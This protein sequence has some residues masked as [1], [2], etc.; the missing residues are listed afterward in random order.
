MLKKLAE[1]FATRRAVKELSA[2]PVFETGRE[3]LRTFWTEHEVSKGFSPGFVQDQA[4]ELADRIGQIIAD[5]NPVQRNRTE[6]STWVMECSKFQVLVLPPEPEEDATGLRGLYGITGELKS[7]VGL[8]ASKNK[9]LG[10]FL[11]GMAPETDADRS[12]AILFRYRLLWSGMSI[13]N[14]LRTPLN[15]T[16]PVAKQ[17]WFWPFF[18]T[19]CGYA[20]Y[21]YRSDAELEPTLNADMG[22]ASLDALELSTFVNMVV[23]GAQYPDFEWEQAYQKVLPRRQQ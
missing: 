22:R 21:V 10:Q 15:D 5:P 7:Q 16:H 3:A 12:D 8:L 20:E 11:Y 4:K 1:A 17:D 9:E 2:N 23:N 13:F 18:A 14:A 6:L 19:Q